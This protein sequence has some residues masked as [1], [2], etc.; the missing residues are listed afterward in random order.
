MHLFEQLYF[1]SFSYLL[2]ITGTKQWSQIAV[3]ENI[4][5]E[6]VPA[7]RWMHSAVSMLDEDQK[8]AMYIFG[9]CSKDYSSMEDLWKLVLAGIDKYILIY[10]FFILPFGFI[11]F[12]FLTF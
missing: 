1:I 9:G 4:E 12:Y 6:W 8:K 10:F 5:N 2:S 7:G 3:V 11:Y